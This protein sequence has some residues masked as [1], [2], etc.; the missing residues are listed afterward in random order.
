A[1]ISEVDLAPLALELALWGS[2]DGALLPEA[3]PPARLA[4]AR[5]L[6]RGLGALD[7]GGAITA[8][9]RQLAGLGVH[10]RLGRMIQAGA[11]AG[12]LRTACQLAALLSEGDLLRGEPSVDLELRLAVLNRQEGGTVARG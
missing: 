6:L 8:A 3:P 10:P 12:S 4:A 7:A 9:G 1:E 11:A 5:E 2:R